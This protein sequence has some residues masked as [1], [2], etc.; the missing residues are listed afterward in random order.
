[1]KRSTIVDFISMLFILL[2]IYAA[3]SKLMDFE[4][5]R[6]QLGQSPLLRLYSKSISL[7]IPVIEVAIS[8]LL[9]T[10]KFRLIGLYASFTL[11]I[12]FTAYIIAIT[13]FS[14]NI[15]C[16]CGGVLQN[17]SWNQH[18]IFNIIFDVFAVIG[19]FLYRLKDFQKA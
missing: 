19:I 11:M 3:S 10:A 15:P 18:L 12:M 7:F 2:F 1:M 14:D 13:R 16:S 5:F 17:M 6:V 4:N 9:I 8:L